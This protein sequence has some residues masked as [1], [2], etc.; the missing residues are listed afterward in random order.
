MSLDRFADHRYVGARDTMVVYDCE[1]D[2]QVE[3]LRRRIE[4][5]DLYRRN[6]LQAFAPDTEAESANRGFRPQG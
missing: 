6:L 3:A 1:D 5:D 2:D 4:R